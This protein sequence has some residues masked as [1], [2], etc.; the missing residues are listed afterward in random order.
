[1]SQYELLS[2]NIILTIKDVFACTVNLQTPRKISRA[3]CRISWCGLLCSFLRLECL[4]YAT[5]MTFFQLKLL[6]Q[7]SP[8]SVE[9]QAPCSMLKKSSL[10]TFGALGS[11]R[12]SRRFQN[13]GLV[14]YR[15]RDLAS[16]SEICLRQK[17]HEP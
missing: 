12:C 10:H 1:M 7:K 11:I 13:T 17:L 2:L 14:V 6:L 3:H 9:E 4:P 15:L 5:L 8:Y 16:H